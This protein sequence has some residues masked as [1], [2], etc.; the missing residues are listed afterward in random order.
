MKGDIKVRERRIPLTQWVANSWSHVCS[1]KEMI[2][3]SFKKCRHNNNT[4]GGSEN[5]LVNMEGLHE[6]VMPRVDRQHRGL[7]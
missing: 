1:K 5:G 4:S 2:H 6:Y 7:T 3:R